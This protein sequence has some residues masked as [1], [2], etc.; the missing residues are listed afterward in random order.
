MTNFQQMS[1]RSATARDNCMAISSD[2]QQFIYIYEV[3]VGVLYLQNDL[4]PMRDY[5]SPH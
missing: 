2:N 1:K 3:W 5:H 4:L